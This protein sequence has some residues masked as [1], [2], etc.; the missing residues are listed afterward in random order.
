MGAGP[1]GE[2]E[3]DQGHQPSDARL[4]GEEAAVERSSEE[5]GANTLLSASVVASS[6]VCGV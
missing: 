2:M 5:E 3:E 6:T 1:G 4:A